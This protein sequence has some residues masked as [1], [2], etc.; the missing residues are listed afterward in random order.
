MIIITSVLPKKELVFVHFFLEALGARDLYT[1]KH[2]HHVSRIVESIFHH[3]P[4]TIRKK[5]HMEK[6]LTA[7]LLH[8][9]GKLNVPL[10]I[11]N[12]PGCLTEEEWFVMYAHPRDGKIFLQGTALEDIGDWILYHHERM[13]G[14]GYYKL[15][16]KDIPLESKIITIADT[17]SALRTHRPYRTAISLEKSIDIL[18]EMAGTQLDREILSYFLSIDKTALEKLDCNCPTCITHEKTMKN[19]SF[20]S[21]FPTAGI[22]EYSPS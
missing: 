22:T 2:S 19:I 7:A 8:D 12:K 17:F 9:I 13:D 4:E 10:D 14:R 16:G 20:D 5:L 18:H 21:I 3:L 1:Q 11:L 6:L 15:E